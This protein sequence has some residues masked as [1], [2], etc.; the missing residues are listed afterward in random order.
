M[1]Y[2]TLCLPCDYVKVYQRVLCMPARQRLR[3]ILVR[4]QRP[5][6]WERYWNRLLLSQF[7]LDT[8]LETAFCRHRSISTILWGL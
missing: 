4:Q 2:F 7:K 8:V 1:F 3:V 5:Q 6:V